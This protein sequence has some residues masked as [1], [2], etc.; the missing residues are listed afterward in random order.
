M[1]EERQPG[2]VIAMMEHIR[3]A[4]TSALVVTGTEAFP[5]D[6]FS[7]LYGD[8]QGDEVAV[9]IEPLYKPGTLHALCSQN[10]ILGICIEAL[11]VNI[12]G[13]GHTITLLEGKP[14]NKTEK[15]ML[16]SLFAN[17][18]PGKTMK[19][20]RR[21]IRIDREET[22]NGYLEVLST[23]DGERVMLNHLPAEN[24]RLVKLG[25]PTTVTRTITR[26]GKDKEV[27]MSVRE[28]RFCQMVNGTKV[29]YRE[30]NSSRQL[31]KTTGKW[32]KPGE[33]LPVEDRA[34]EVIHFR[35][36]REP[37]SAYGVPRWI[38]QLPS[39]LGSRK[40]EEFNLEFFD[41]G[42]IPPAMVIIEGGY[43]G[44]DVKKEIKQ[45]A[46]AKNA[47]HRLSIIEAVSSSGSLDSAGTVRVRVERFGADRQ[48]DAM[49]QEYDHNCG[50]HVRL[51]FRLPPL[52]IG[53]A[54][55]LNFA[56]AYTAYMVAEAQVFVPE[57]EIFD[58]TINTTIVKALGVKNY[59]FSSLPLTLVDVANQFKAL[60]M[61][62][63]KHISGQQVVDRLNDITGL[64]LEY[65]E[66]K[67]PEPPQPP[68]LPGQP[69]P[70]EAEEGKGDPKKPKK[71]PE[72]SADSTIKRGI[73]EV[74]KPTQKAEK[75]L[76]DLGLLDLHQ[77]ADHLC[78]GH[79][80]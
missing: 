37:K 63:G 47:S 35:L 18:Y 33:V 7:G 5:E 22:G 51:S 52:F 34:S 43:L 29:F 19:Q 72:P 2:E 30:F 9:I 48:K 11:E 65:E 55:D 17:P 45:Q 73:P 27:Q 13:T 76:I 77:C 62:D 24:T 26:N 70:P 25:A 56:T 3:K 53:D 32:A 8:L 14:E 38:A 49:F 40:S 16:E 78:G 59:K 58:E 61:L 23:A 57:R 12:D 69:V 4:D 21:E 42:G 10:N 74:A 68:A 71:A 75:A 66:Q 67:E 60:E 6:E 20:I 46:S 36:K 28:R 31:S 15:E 44:V 1:S 50:E 41:S 79:P 39:I 54:A 80:E 64:N